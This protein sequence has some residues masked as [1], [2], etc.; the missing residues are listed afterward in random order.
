[1]LSFL[2]N[3]FTFLFI[4]SSSV[5]FAQEKDLNQFDAQGKRHGKWMKTFEGTDQIRYKGQFNHGKET[6]TF[7]FY[8]FGEDKHPNATKTYNEN[9]ELVVAKFYTKKGKLLTEGFFKGKKREG[10]WIYYHKKNTDVVMMKEH[11]VNNK[12]D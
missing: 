3:G 2:K 4:L 8:K 10:E 7:K 1:M 12:L 5:L 9:N 11:Y 6:G